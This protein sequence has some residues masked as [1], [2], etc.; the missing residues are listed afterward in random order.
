MQLTA[1]DSFVLASEA[2]LLVAIGIR[3]RDRLHTGPD[4]VLGRRRM[5]APFT[6]AALT[7]NSVPI[8]WFLAL[9]GMAYTMG[10]SAIWIALSLFA[11]AAIGARFVAPRLRA[12]TNLRQ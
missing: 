2:V 5:N 4:L 11:G 3:W 9:I 10:R 8:W 12:L 6:E 1:L 7:M